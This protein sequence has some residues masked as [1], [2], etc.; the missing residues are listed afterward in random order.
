MREKARRR[1]KAR[2]LDHLAHFTKKVFDEWRLKNGETVRVS[3]RPR[4]RP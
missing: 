2:E 4:C 1:D 3:H